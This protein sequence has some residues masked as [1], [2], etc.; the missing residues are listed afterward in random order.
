MKHQDELLARLRLVRRLAVCDLILLLL[1]LGASALHQR[2]LVHWL[3]P[4]HGGNFLLLM[5]AVATGASDGLWGWWFPA[6][7]LLT[8]GPLGAYLGDDR[9]RSAK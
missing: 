6:L 9:I 2:A 4:L 8:G 3:G 5:V 7:V 1:L